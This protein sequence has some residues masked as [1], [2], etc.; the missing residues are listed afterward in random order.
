MEVEYL[1][2]CCDAVLVDEPDTVDPDSAGDT[3]AGI[4]STCGKPARFYGVDCEP[5]EDYD[6]SD[7]RCD[8]EQARQDEQASRTYEANRLRDRDG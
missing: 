8:A 7:T 3:L 4:C 2:R 1:S 5:S 6:D